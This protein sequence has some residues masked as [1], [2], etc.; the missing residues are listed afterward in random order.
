MKRVRLFSLHKTH[1]V[2]C[3]VTV[4]Q[5]CSFTDE[6]KCLVE[7]VRCSW[8][9]WCDARVLGHSSGIIHINIYDYI[10]HVKSQKW[11]K[12]AG[13]TSSKYLQ[14][15]FVVAESIQNLKKKKKGQCCQLSNHF[16]HHCHLIISIV[17]VVCFSLIAVWLGKC[18]YCEL[19]VI[20]HAIIYDSLSV[21]KHQVKCFWYVVVV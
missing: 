15:I 2:Y 6:A 21:D 13:L 1:W 4:T 7:S 8:V 10:T 17:S 19:D 11:V 20:I 9:N 3:I 14:M 5:S 12:A 16:G 18:C